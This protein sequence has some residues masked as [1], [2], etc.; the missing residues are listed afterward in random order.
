MIVNVERLKE[1]KEIYVKMYIEV[2][3]ILTAADKVDQD[4]TTLRNMP[5]KDF[6]RTLGFNIN[7]DYNMVYGLQQEIH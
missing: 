6:I 3:K 7:I 4:I 1:L 2:E 5:E